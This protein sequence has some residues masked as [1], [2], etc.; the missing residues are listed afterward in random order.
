M[1]DPVSPT[2]DSSINGDPP[3]LSAVEQAV[4]AATD[5]SAVKP[6]PDS[7]S[8]ISLLEQGEA[9]PYSAD[10]RLA[11]SPLEEWFP[12]VE[13]RTLV[14][15]LGGTCFQSSDGTLTLIVESGNH[16]PAGAVRYTRAGP[17]EQGVIGYWGPV[18]S[19][20]A[21]IGE[22]AQADRP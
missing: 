6:A 1:T 16:T 20:A 13:W 19:S 14:T 10:E 9:A 18:V 5:A 15:W 2:T 3:Q 8:P 7:D 12:G 17:W 21:E 22:L 4:Q 11:A